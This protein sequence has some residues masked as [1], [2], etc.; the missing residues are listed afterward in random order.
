MLE[1][2]DWALVD[3]REPIRALLRSPAGSGSRTRPRPGGPRS[4][5]PTRTHLPT[6][7]G[8]DTAPPWSGW[9]WASPSCRTPRARPRWLRSSWPRPA[10]TLLPLREALAGAP[11]A[12]HPEVFD[13]LARYLPAPLRDRRAQVRPLAVD[14]CGPRLRVETSDGDHDVRLAWRDG[15]HTVAELRTQMSLLVGCPFRDLA[16]ERPLS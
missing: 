13:A 4:R 2:T 1:L 7:S 5:S 10:R 12:A 3:L 16:A 11:R 6:C 9:T 14:R 8:S 15:A